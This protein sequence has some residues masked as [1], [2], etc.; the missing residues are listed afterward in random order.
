MRA[1]LTI[2]MLFA[3]ASACAACGSGGGSNSD[4]MV[5]VQAGAFWMGCNDFV[6]TDCLDYEL[7]YHQVELD[8]YSI[9]QT[10]VTQAQYSACVE[11]GECTEP[12]CNWNPRAKGDH[13]VV[14]VT[15]QQ[16]E[17]FCSWAE[18]RLCTEAEWEK[19]ARGTD[20][21]LYPW[22]NG[23]ADCD[24]AVIREA[25]V[26]CQYAGSQAVGS[27]PAGKSPCGVL[28]MAGNVLEWVADW[29]ATDYYAES[30][31]ENPKGPHDGES[32]VMRGGSFQASARFVRASYR[33]QADPAF[34]YHDLGLRCC[35]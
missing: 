32:R 24:L 35:R 17:V 10:E 13:P 8:A 25:D 6:D 18:K 7:P 33:A 4:G 22:G 12:D 11:A 5:N 2:S 14:C 26:T 30:P 27:L 15:W 34:G 28:D 21:C 9:D 16:A 19:A 3:C 23:Q 31:P 20:G 29:F 1:R